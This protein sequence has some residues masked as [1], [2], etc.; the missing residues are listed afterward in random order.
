[1]KTFL[2]PADDQSNSGYQIKQSLIA[3]GSGGLAGRGFGQSVQKFSYLPEPMTDSIFAVIGEEFGFL[4][5]G[6]IVTLF[7]ALLARGYTIASKVPDRFGAVLAVGL[8]TLIATQAFV[9]M[10]ALLGLM[11]LTG[12]P[13]VFISHGG[14]AMFIALGVV[15]IL[16]NISRYAA[17]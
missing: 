4:G 5:T 16:L 10:A 3:I 11:P 6:I 13:L 1:V 14:T 9:N 8:I 12:I 17:K 7:A 2:N 15:G